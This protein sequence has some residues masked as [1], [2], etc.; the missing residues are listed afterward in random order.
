MTSAPNAD[1]TATAAAKAE[2]EQAVFGQVRTYA[3]SL[4]SVADSLD[5]LAAQPGPNRPHAYAEVVRLTGEA[6]EASRAAQFNL[7]SLIHQAPDKVSLSKLASLARVSL[8]TLRNNLGLNPG[9]EPQSHV[10]PS[11]Y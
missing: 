11:P 9:R 1:E 8:N 4:R 10:G 3:D 5:A 6:M 2:K 7:V